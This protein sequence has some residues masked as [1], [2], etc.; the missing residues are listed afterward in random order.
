MMLQLHTTIIDN[1]EDLEAACRKYCAA[2]GEKKI[3]P[4]AGKRR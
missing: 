2:V 4:A 3:F 1:L